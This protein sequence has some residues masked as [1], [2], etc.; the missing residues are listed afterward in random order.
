M[1]FFQ[2][3]DHHEQTRKEQ[4]AFAVHFEQDLLALVIAQGDHGNPSRDQRRHCRI[5]RQAGQG[6]QWD[7]KDQQDNSHKEAGQTD[8]GKMGM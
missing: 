2:S 7:V 8:A 1:N 5:D 4:N 6:A 3:A